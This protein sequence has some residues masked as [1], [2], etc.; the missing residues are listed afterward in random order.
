MRGQ[1]GMGGLDGVGW[2]VMEG[3]LVAVM[4]GDG[5]MQR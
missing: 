1:V 3:A 4:M 2:V 5:M